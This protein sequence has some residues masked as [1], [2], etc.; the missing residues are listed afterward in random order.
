M[1]LSLRVL[2]LSGASFSTISLE[3][4]AYAASTSIPGVSHSDTSDPVEDLLEI[5]LVDETCG[6]GTEAIGAGMVG[7]IVND[8]TSGQVEQIGVSLLGD[9]DL[10]IENAGQASVRASAGAGPDS[11]GA[12][13]TAIVYQGFE[14]VGVAGDDVTLDL[15]NSGGLT[16]EAA[17]LAKGD[18]TGFGVAIATIDGG[19]AQRAA[20]T[21]VGD[22]AVSLTNEGSIDISV[23]AWARAGSQL[24]VGNILDGVRQTAQTAGSGKADVSLTNKGEITIHAKAVSGPANEGQTDGSSIARSRVEGVDQIAYA[25][26]TRTSA[27][28]ASGGTQ[29]LSWSKGGLGQGLAA[30]DNQGLLD[31]SASVIAEGAEAAALSADLHGLEQTVAGTSAEAQLTNTGAIKISADGLAV[32]GNVAAG[33]AYAFGIWQSAYATEIVSQTALLPDGSVAYIRGQRSLGPSNASLTN[34]GAV[35]VAAVVHAEALGDGATGTAAVAGAKAVAGAIRQYSRGSDAAA[36][37]TNGGSVNVSAVAA[38]TASGGVAASAAAEGFHQGALAAGASSSDYFTASGNWDHS[39]FNFYF[40]GPAATSLTNNGTIDVSADAKGIAADGPTFVGAEARGI[41]LA[42][43]GTHASVSLDNLGQVRVAAKGSASGMTGVASAIAAGVTQSFTTAT[44]LVIDIANSGLIDVDANAH[45]LQ[46]NGATAIAAAI[47]LTER[48]IGY[49]QAKL[50]LDNQG[51]LN[52][53]AAA[54]AQGGYFA[55][56]T[57]YAT[58]VN[59]H[60]LTTAADLNFENSGAIT[61]GADIQATADGDTG[62]AGVTAYAHGYIAHAIDL[63]V[64]IANAGTIDV[65]ARA[66][67]DGADELAK[68]SAVGIAV[69]GATGTTYGVVYGGLHGTLENSGMLKVLAEA[70]GR[71]DALDGV[72][73][74]AQGIGILMHS[75]TNAMTLTN[76]GSILVDS[77]GVSSDPAKA[78]AGPARAFGLQVNSLLSIADPASD[79]VFTLNNS[80]TIIARQS[81]DGGETWTHGVAIDVGHAGNNSVVNLLGGGRIYGGIDVQ[82]GDVINVES[83]A[84]VFD[85]VV[86]RSCPFISEGDPNGCGVGTLNIVNGGNLVLADS[87]FTGVASMYDGPATAFVDT[88][89]VAA[90]GTLTLQLQPAANGVQTAGSYQQI[91]ANTANLAGTLAADFSTENGLLADSYSWDNVIQA[92]AVSGTFDQCRLA[93]RYAGSALLDLTC[94]YGSD[95]NL[96]LALTRVAFNAVDGVNRNGT[97]VAGA[98]DSIYDSIPDGG[99]ANLVGDLFAIDGAAS[100][101]KALNQISGSSYANYLQ[102]FPSLGVRFNDIADKAIGC[103]GRTLG[104]AVSECRSGKVRAWGQLDY[105]DRKAGGDAEAGANRSKRFAGLIGV[106]VMV[107]PSALVGFSAGAVSNHN[108]QAGDTIK[109]DGYSVGAYGVFDPGR[110]YVKGFANFSRFD[111][112]SK[113]RIDFDPLGGTFVSTLEGRPDVRMWS[114]GLHGGYR[115]GVGKGSTLTPYLN[116]DYADAELNDFS[117]RTSAGDDGAE[118]S[119]SRGR[120]KHLFATGGFK[121]TGH[122]G[123][124][125]PE[126]RLGYRH[127]FGSTR[128]QFAASA[129]GGQDTDFEVISAAE[130]RG[131]VLAGVGIGGKLGGF[132]LKAAYDGEFSSD[133]INHSVSF[134]IVLPLGVHAEK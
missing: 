52:V 53:H 9:V 12:T 93:G 29:V 108:R 105:S 72:A 101:N 55:G 11:I 134:K 64:Q 50:A 127:R 97:S 102:S 16:V 58:G 62:F 120:T 85:G 25:A 83:G 24:A 5:C 130:T 32:A 33:S 95:G 71:L 128:S 133:V 66:R 15:S 125:E 6:S 81:V 28:T 39:S 43:A 115:V 88:L 70:S 21:A 117:E 51:V 23:D 37:L 2:L 38:A 31:V 14:Q 18:G 110:F 78:Y 113:R 82:S 121:W 73:T 91:F 80:G 124:V 131:S 126:V 20:A 60:T 92:N 74:S 36:T 111:G 89:N 44:N 19:V 84:T 94:S 40:A 47:G 75:G 22:A 10:A 45:S 27:F 67:A 13:A 104:A 122:I 17:A 99:L 41:T 96:D 1:N 118:L 116:L 86:N 107:S 76:S 114:L 46:K 34:E 90:D 49:D 109:G 7:A 61:V 79:A 56:G 69:I 26:A 54:F 4:P 63:S 112:S 8:A 77:I 100:Y 132:D 30:F 35:D 106:D 59:Q 48:G 3:T 68:A 65:S 129:L 123:R 103:D 119:V 57:V 98:I 42:A 87:R